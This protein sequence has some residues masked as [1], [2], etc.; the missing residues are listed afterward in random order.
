MQIRNATEADIDGILTVW[1]WL[2]RETLVTFRDVEHTPES[3]HEVL[4]TTR[5]A[6]RPFLVVETDKIVGFA[7]Y[8]QFRA[9]PGY[10]H[11]MEH[12]I[13]LLPDA[14]GQGIGRALMAQIFDHAR[15]RGVHSLFAGVSGA[16]PAGVP[17]HARLGFEEIGR[18][19]EVGYKNGEWLDL[20]LMQKFL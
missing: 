13:A 14:W 12:S 5:A 17:F 19:P 10:R 9:S 18:L 3:L 7:T 15:A 8:S 6:D 1:N 2:I 20:V 4:Q 16:N 11:T